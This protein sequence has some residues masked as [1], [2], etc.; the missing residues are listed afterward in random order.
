[1]SRSAWMLA[2]ATSVVV[3]CSR[4]SPP[5]STA[6]GQDAAATPPAQ[7][8]AQPSPPPAA[9]TTG[10][11]EAAAPTPQSQ[12]R[13][14]AAAP[15]PS[16]TA[17]Q[18]ATAPR[19]AAPAAPPPEP[20]A[21]T[22]RDVTI[23]AGTSFSVTVLSTLAS[24]TS[25]VEDPVRASLAKAVIV[26]GHA[27]VPAGSEI[28]GTVID[29]KESGRVK[30]KASVAFRF[31]HLKVRGETYRIQTARVTR[32]AVQD[33]RSDLKK[34]GVGGGLGAIVGG[35]VGGGKGAAIG[36]VAGGTGAVLGTKG[37]EVQVEPGTVVTALL[38]ESLTVPVPVP[39]T[40]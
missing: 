31:E 32:E 25:K 21:P 29:V 2:F 37:D 20:P 16:G 5:Q 13:L 12:T 35:V 36:A 11:G 24:N 17:A 9:A 18:T 26:S 33:K 27:A 15:A 8:E 39:N 14:P 6:A 34:G 38:Q 28:T 30:G 22:F 4:P 10:H 19:A 40:R 7:K 1:M 3:S 23:P